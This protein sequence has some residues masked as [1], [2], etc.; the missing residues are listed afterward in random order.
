MGD[1]MHDDLSQ[2]SQ[3]L[4][5]GTVKFNGGLERSWKMGVPGQAEIPPEMKITIGSRIGEQYEVRRVLGG[6]GKSGMGV[7][8][9][10]YDHNVGQL[11]ALKTFQ[12]KYLFSDQAKDS[13][14]QEA[15]AWVSLGSHPNIVQAVCV[16]SLD[17]R[18]FIVLEY[19]DPDDGGRN[20]MAHYLKGPISL[21]QALEW[22]IQFCD[23]MAYAASQDVTP[24]RDIKPDN[25][26]ITREG[27]LKVTDFG[28]AKVWEGT[29]L[30]AG[31]DDGPMRA[32]VGTS[33]WM[34]PEQFEGYSDL[35]SDIYSFGIILYQM[36]SGGKLPFT[37]DS[38]YGYRKAHKSQPVPKLKSRL[39]PVIK[40]CLKKTPEERYEDFRSLRADLARL[41]KARTGII[42]SAPPEKV[43]PG[44]WEYNNMGLALF[45]MGYVDEA[46]WIYAKALRSNQAFA[47]QYKAIVHNNLG[48]AYD[49]R[50]QLD[51][52]MDEYIEAIIMNPDMADAHNNLGTALRARGMLDDAILEYRKALRLKPDYAMSRH[53]LGLLYASK[54]DLDGAIKEYLE[55]IKLKPGFVEARIN[56]GLAYAMKGRFDLAIDEYRKAASLRPDDPIVHFN[57]ANALQ[58][59]GH[60]DDAINEYRVALQ[61]EPD[62]AEARLKLGLLLEDHC[63]VQDAINEYIG[64]LR[65][66]PGHHDAM[67]SL[68]RA[69]KK[70]GTSDAAV[71]ECLRLM[72]RPDCGK[73]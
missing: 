5:D 21:A 34:A 68:E 38:V 22:A 51:L 6:E 20:T 24:H 14:K 47:G 62:H 32:A 49:A 61:L 8:Y 50:G 44:L 25:I 35:R 66:E 58:A 10:C 54:G 3:A 16:E 46:I 67:A 53:N 45:N 36:A 31:S 72:A 63:L 2:G 64:V 7:V 40:K 1:E 15:R 57:L 43:E 17:N 29:W 11:Y 18:L 23:G 70:S 69:L 41:Y 12:D 13:F 27:T 30:S 28:L 33:P 73:E 52:A 55:A 37:A 19:I 9:V 56:L 48:V 42:P 65:L 26:M 4:Q 59:N 71:Q 60:G 39:F